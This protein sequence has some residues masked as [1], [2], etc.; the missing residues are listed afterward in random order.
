MSE[1]NWYASGEQSITGTV[2]IT[3]MKVMYAA[4]IIIA[5]PLGLAVL[6]TPE[7]TRQLL[8]IPA[9]E[10]MSYGI[11]MGAIPLAFGLAGIAGLY[12]PL[13]CSPILGL[14]AL[15]KSMFLIAVI[16]PLLATG[17]IPAYALP[18]IGIFVFFII[19]DVLAIPFDYIL[20][21]PA[22]AT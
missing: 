13:R 15:Y 16:L 8:G 18:L 6:V 9:V 7:T 17:G 22:T 10:P 12:A 11:G 3:R 4:N 1:V 19:G 14:Q 5:G 20:S 21:R 2:H